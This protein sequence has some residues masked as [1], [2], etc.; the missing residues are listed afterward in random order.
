MP[1]LNFQ[2]LATGSSINLPRGE[3]NH[4]R[5]RRLRDGAVITLFNSRGDTLSATLQGRHAIITEMSSSRS[6]WMSNDDDGDDDKTPTDEN[7]TS[8]STTDLDIDTNISKRRT[9]HAIV[10]AMKSSSRSDWLVEKLTELG[11]SSISIAH[12]S[13]CSL[14]I[15]VVQDRTARWTRVAVAAA[16]QSVRLDVPAVCGVSWKEALYMVSITS[17]AFVLC[18]GGDSLLSPGVAQLIRQRREAVFFIGPE[19][20]L[21]ENEIKQLADVGAVPIGL[22]SARLRAE[23]AATITAGIIGQILDYDVDADDDNV[24]S[25]NDDNKTASFTD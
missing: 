12:T 15:D 18:S 22:G 25:N 13:R 1:N 24:D 20:G 17:P 19:G 2:Q 23:T 9:I 8:S 6:S 21:T 5:A 4:L 7:E 14:P 10:A 16:K 3:F 11:T